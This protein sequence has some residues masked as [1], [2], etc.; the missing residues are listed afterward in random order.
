MAQTIVEVDTQGV[1][2]DV[3]LTKSER[4]VL[5][6][7][8]SG[9]RKAF[10]IGDIGLNAQKRA[11]QAGFPRWAAMAITA[12]EAGIGPKRLSKLC[13]VSERFG[14]DIRRKYHL[15]PFSVFE[16]ALVFAPGED[17]QMLQYALEGMSD[18]KRWP[19]AERI[20]T[21]FR[22]NILGA[23]TGH[24][25]R[26][27]GKPVTDGAGNIVRSG[28]TVVTDSRAYDIPAVSTRPRE[29]VSVSDLRKLLSK[30]KSGKGS[31]GECIQD[32]EN[33]TKS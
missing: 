7:F 6:E 22:R 28:V 26:A 20:A 17:E 18:T 29:W 3:V 16:E 25:E 9:S 2:Y 15:F 31:V 1:L 19:G 33:V 24:P 13:A 32:L 12:E 11:E 10:E 23:E 27:D 5:S 21:D 4:K 8:R 14:E 30:W